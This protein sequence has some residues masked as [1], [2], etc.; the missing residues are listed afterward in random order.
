MTHKGINPLFI[1]ALDILLNTLGVF[2]ILNFLNTRLAGVPPVPVNPPVKEQKAAPKKQAE[3]SKPRSWWSKPAEPQA[4]RTSGNRPVEPYVQSPKPNQPTADPKPDNP[5]PTSTNKPAS[6]PQDPVA[7]DLMKQTK[8]A[9]TILL[10]QADQSKTSVEFMLRQGNRTW[11]PGRASK[12]QDNGFQY[13][14]SLGYFY[15][16]EIQPGTYEVL[17]RVKRGQK[18]EGRKSF[19]MF[20]KIIPT[21]QKTQTYSF[22]TFAVDGSAGDWVSAGTFTIQPSGLEIPVE[23]TRC[24][25]NGHHS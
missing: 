10:Q 18:S 12:F 2:I 3:V 23:T 13:E 9:V 4:G 5:Q 24:I 7:V 11:K 20:G 19:G 25:P 6:T 21:G 8:G 17:V 1:S 22:G 16:A 14:K 15:Q